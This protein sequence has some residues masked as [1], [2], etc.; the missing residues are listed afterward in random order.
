[1]PRLELLVGSA[2]AAEDAVPPEQA[3]WY[4][5]RNSVLVVYY[6]E[7]LIMAAEGLSSD[8]PEMRRVGGSRPALQSLCPF[9][10]QGGLHIWEELLI[11]ERWPVMDRRIATTSLTVLCL[12]LLSFKGVLQTVPSGDDLRCRH[13]LLWMWP[14]LMNSSA[15]SAVYKGVPFQEKT[16]LLSCTRKTFYNY[17]CL[18][19][20]EILCGILSRCIRLPRAH[21][22]VT[23]CPRHWEDSILRNH[24]PGSTVTPQLRL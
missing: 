14:C 3:C 23:R 22:S 2:T 7:F 4:N 16:A 6:E 20:M 24:T 19:G 9:L 5:E 13:L 21:L 12:T 15:S 10:A 8:E 11:W 17:Y 18:V 1:M